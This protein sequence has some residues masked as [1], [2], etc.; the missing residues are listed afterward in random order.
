[1]PLWA[2]ALLVA[3]PAAGCR[4]ANPYAKP[5]A[6]KPAPRSVEP[7]RTPPEQ[8]QPA[9]LALLSAD[10]RRALQAST[11]DAA[12]RFKA[13]VCKRAP[14]R[15]PRGE[16]AASGGVIQALVG[17]AH[18]ACVNAMQTPAVSAALGFEPAVG[19]WRITPTMALP[20]LPTPNAPALAT[21][22]G[23]DACEG[24][25][26]IVDEVAFAT[27]GCSPFD[28]ASRL[29][30]SPA[31]LDALTRAVILAA[32]SHAREQR[33]VAALEQLLR[34]IRFLDVATD[35]AALDL[36]AAGS[37]AQL[38]MLQAALRVIEV[39]TGRIAPGEAQ[40][41][42]LAV[43]DVE[44]G[45]PRLAV[46]LRAEAIARTLDVYRDAFAPDAKTPATDELALAWKA[47]DRLREVVTA[48]CPNTPA[49]ACLH[50]LAATVKPPSTRPT[51]VTDVSPAQLEERALT[52]GA[53][54]FA[55][56]AVERLRVPGAA[57]LALRALR[58]HLAWLGSAPT[59]CPTK[60]A[61]EKI[62]PRSALVDPHHGNALRFPAQ[63]ETLGI[64]PSR[65]L[66]G[67]GDPF[68]LWTV[69]CTR[70]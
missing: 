17:D 23:A 53:S 68:A 14:L 18:A 49:G 44:A 65:P 3:L 2:L 24:L 6:V 70:Y 12:K 8:K 42:V 45:R 47:H 34:G 61:L 52:D 4:E 35:G 15:A 66:D 5:R 64:A 58:L 40:R 48:A 11:L 30:P 28:P 22:E 20:L 19:A 50:G 63:G 43:A 67:R 26:R 27:T 38:T 54:T 10:E 21:L 32:Y 59:A 29:M 13:R 39:K 1:M 60:L 9:E 56:R 7:A 33:P 55:Q 69:G 37:E 25:L 16:G 51:G 46:P 62:A 31:A 36:F 57:T 41:L